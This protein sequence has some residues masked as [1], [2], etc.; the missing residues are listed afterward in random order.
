MPATRPSLFRWLAGV[1]CSCLFIWLVASVF[2]DQS[3]PL[4]YD[5]EVDDYV[6]MPYA[7]AR[8]RSEGWAETSLGEHGFFTGED[9]IAS[10]IEPKI[11][12]WGDSHVS[13]YHVPLEHKIS[14]RYNELATPGQPRCI[15]YGRDGKGVVDYFY[16]MPKYQHRFAN[17]QGNAILINSLEDVLPYA[18]QPYGRFLKNPWRLEEHPF[19]LN[20]LG[21]A[22]GPWIYRLK[23]NT[24][25]DLYQDVK[26]SSLRF[27]PGPSPAQLDTP[28]QAQ[29]PLQKG[30]DFLLN[31][32][33]EQSNGSLVIIYCPLTTPRLEAGEVLFDNPE[34]LLVA[35]FA[36]ACAR[37]KVHFIDMTKAFSHLHQAKGVFPRG[38]FN[39]PPGQGHMN[40]HGLAAVASALHEHYTQAKQH[41][42]L[43]DL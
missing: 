24:F 22:L 16:A 19:A 1:L 40:R 11:I 34:A 2:T 14:S 5:S 3:P 36:D 38:F 18:G 39:T 26:T 29:K 17:I 42:I 9:S 21:R 10:S 43:R 32:L 33:R 28:A 8:A 41:A 12:L 31:Q 37:N 20:A 35:Q 7:T 25:Y 6:P 13:A 15:S 30:W 27:H 23:L 4:V